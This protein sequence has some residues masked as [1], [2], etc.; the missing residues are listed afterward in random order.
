MIACH[1]TARFQPVVIVRI[2]L[3]FSMRAGRGIMAV[4]LACD[5]MMWISGRGLRIR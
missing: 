5:L 2:T 1:G 3:F 4:I